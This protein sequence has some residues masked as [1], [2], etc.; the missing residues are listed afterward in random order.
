MI[1]QNPWAWLGLVTALLPVIIHLFGRGHARVHRFPSLRF[2]A[3]SRLLPT[4]RTRLNDLLLLVVRASVLAV[5]VAALAR[6]L[7]VTSR[8]T[9]AANAMLARVVIADTSVQGARAAID[10]VSQ[11]ATANTNI[12]TADVSAA[13]PG[14]VAWLGA[15]RMRGEI[16][17]LSRFPVGLLDSADIASIPKH[18][19]LRF[20]R[21]PGG[22][23][24][25]LELHARSGNGETITRIAAS[26]DRTDA[27][28]SAATT[29]G[30]APS[31]I[32]IF[33]GPA[34]RRT[35]EAARLAAASVPVALPTD[36]IASIAVVQPG[37]ES[38][39][40]LLAST[41][42]PRHAWM[43]DVVA[44]V[45]NDPS[46]AEAARR[47]TI[48]ARPDSG[49]SLVIA[50]T[51]SGRPVVL[52]G[53]GTIAGRDR[54]TFYS[55]ADAGS[56]T[57]AALL[58]AVTQATSSAPSPRSLEPLTIPDASLAAWQRSPGD[59]R[60]S[61]ATTDDESDGRWLWGLVLLLLGVEGWLRRERRTA[62]A[63]YEIARDR[64]A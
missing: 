51:D 17:I 11:G 59:V 33:A 31:T 40:S 2:L 25:P 46:L 45:A 15:Q 39:T 49:H 50:R 16:T 36:S 26:P 32:E 6:P 58:A 38:R 19:G 37:Y 13:L 27:E 23:T 56:L 28:W 10:S 62:A 44:R 7:L 42:A 18:I 4:R 63:A 47:A 14:A 52:A 43:M 20:I 35:A 1:W 55:L 8:R 21:A 64:A 29:N 5:A 30:R 57:S 24:G 3:A 48:V 41:V 54:L 61:G 53:E 60:S 34:E 22:S 12:A 9:A